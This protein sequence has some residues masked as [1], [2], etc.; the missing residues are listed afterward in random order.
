MNK[1]LRE[2]KLEVVVLVDMKQNLRI[3]RELQVKKLRKFHHNTLRMNC[4]KLNVV[5]MDG[6]LVTW[7]MIEST[8]YRLSISL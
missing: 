3:V 1:C 4:K 8:K 2:G 5:N 7:S 6:V